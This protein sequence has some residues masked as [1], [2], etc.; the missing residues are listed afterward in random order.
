[1]KKK[2]SK[3]GTLAAA[4]LWT[5]IV[6]LW[7]VTFIIRLSH[8]Y[9]DTALL[10]MTALTLLASMAAAVVNWLRYIHYEE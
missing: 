4:I 6:G 7:L 1:M 8:P 5:A 2:M 9:E 3:R 10:T